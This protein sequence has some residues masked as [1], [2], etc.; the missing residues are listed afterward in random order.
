M[1]ELPEVETIVQALKPCLTGLTPVKVLCHKAKIL[2]TPDLLP[3]A[4]GFPIKDIT[5]KGKLILLWTSPY[6]WL[7]HLKMTGQLWWQPKIFPLPPHTH[8][9]VSFLH[10][11]YQL[12]YADLRQFG[13][14]QIVPETKLAQVPFLQ[15]LGPD[16]LTVTPEIL[17]KQLHKKKAAIKKVLLNQQCLAGLGNIYSDEALW[18]ARIHP[19]TPA[20]TLTPLQIDKLAWAIRKT[21]RRG[22]KLGGTS[23]QNYIQPNGQ[24]GLYQRYRFVYRREGLPCLRCGMSIRRINISSRSSYFCSGCQRL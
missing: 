12:R 10:S 19:L 15:K 3:S 7:I 21:L 9:I 1:P 6:V 5:R 13:Y 14:W 18:L 23:I 16:A 11:D 20:N 4:L 22:L 8:L 2:R 24:K 17:K